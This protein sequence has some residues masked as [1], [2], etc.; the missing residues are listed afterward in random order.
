MPMGIE[1]FFTVLA[2]ILGA[3]ALAFLYFLLRRRQR[4]A[5]LTAAITSLAVLGWYPLPAVDSVA[6]VLFFPHDTAYAPGFSDVVFRKVRRGQSRS[7]IVA[8]LGA[9]LSTVVYREEGIEYWH[10]SRHGKLHDNYWNKII[11]FD[12]RTG[13][14]TRKVSELYSD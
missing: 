3:G 5:L 7:E 13:R 9:P 10:Y 6:S 12:V 11:V 14:V 8:L 2:A 1:G 4:A